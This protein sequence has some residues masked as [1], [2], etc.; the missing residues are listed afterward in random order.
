MKSSALVSLVQSNGQDFEFY[1]TTDAIISA[2]VKDIK[3]EPE[4]YRH[5]DFESVL[6]IGAGNGK[7]PMALREQAG[8][9]SL[10]AIEKSLILCEQLDPNVLIVGTDFAEQSLLSKHVD[11]VFC[12][13][14]YSEFEQWAVKIIRQAASAEVYLVLPRRWQT[15]VPIADALK[16]RDADCVTAVRKGRLTQPH[17]AGLLPYSQPPAEAVQALIENK[18]RK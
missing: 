7:V 15:S 10:H 8:F 4:E 17:V 9:S 13:P 3:R 2:L 6:D 14:P 5:R 12:N 18:D 11:V 16:Y 1:P